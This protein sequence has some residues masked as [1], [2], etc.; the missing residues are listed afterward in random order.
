MGKITDYTVVT[1]LDDGRV[2][3][4]VTIPEDGTTFAFTGASADEVLAKWRK[5]DTWF[6]PNED[7]VS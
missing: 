4:S 3:C 5:F 1:T 7:E 6:T 2:R